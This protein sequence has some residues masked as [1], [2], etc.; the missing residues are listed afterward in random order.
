MAALN[1]VE[2]VAIAECI[3]ILKKDINIL[4]EKVTSSNLLIN[5]SKLTVRIKE[6]S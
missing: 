2:L 1:T 3:D 6:S 5:N 4:K